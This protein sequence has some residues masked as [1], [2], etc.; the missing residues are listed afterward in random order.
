MKLHLIGE[1][2]EHGRVQRRY[3]Y[4]NLRAVVLLLEYGYGGTKKKETRLQ[5]TRHYAIHVVQTEEMNW[6]LSYPPEG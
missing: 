4:L 1:L 2:D 3:I 6:L 5:S